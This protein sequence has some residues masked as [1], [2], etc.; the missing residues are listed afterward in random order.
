MTD[1][2]AS[3]HVIPGPFGGGSGT[4]GFVLGFGGFGPTA[5]THKNDV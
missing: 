1:L 4:F 3:G 2:T 5:N